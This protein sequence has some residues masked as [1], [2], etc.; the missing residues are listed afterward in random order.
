MNKLMEK[1]KLIEGE[2]QKEK[3]RERLLHEQAESKE[4]HKAAITAENQESIGSIQ[5]KSKKTTAKNRSSKSRYRSTSKS[6]EKLLLN[7]IMS[8]KALTKRQPDKK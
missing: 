4:K 6:G 1:K 8:S 3:E 2:I 7:S 5:E